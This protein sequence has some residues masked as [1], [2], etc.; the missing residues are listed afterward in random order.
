MQECAQRAMLSL[1][2]IKG[3]S[4]AAVVI[5][6]E[7]VYARL[8]I[9]VAPTKAS[10]HGCL[11]ERALRA[12]HWLFATRLAPTDTSMH[13]D[14]R[15]CLDMAAPGEGGRYAAWVQAGSMPTV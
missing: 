12:M 4:S 8:A 14:R 7:R 10:T 5:L 11:Q 1:F 2:A 15:G 9:K 3:Y 6:W 13:G